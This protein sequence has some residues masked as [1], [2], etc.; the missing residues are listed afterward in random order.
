MVAA[1]ELN[2]AAQLG[3]P[4]AMTDQVENAG[5]RDDYLKAAEQRGPKKTWQR[6]RT[7]AEMEFGQRRH[8]FGG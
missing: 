6:L 1:V 7:E 3:L 5:G 4:K 2:E 8:G